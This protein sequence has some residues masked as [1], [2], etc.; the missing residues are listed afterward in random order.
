MG[1]HHEDDPERRR[2]GG[3]RWK[4]D[5]TDSIPVIPAWE[6][7]DGL[8]DSSVDAFVAAIHSTNPPGL[9]VPAEHALY[10]WMIERCSD[11]DVAG[12]PIRRNAWVTVATG[13][14]STPYP[15]TRIA[16]QDILDGWFLWNGVTRPDVRRLHTIWT[17]HATEAAW[18]E[19]LDGR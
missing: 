12:D 6:E 17:R 8:T 7:H 4:G 10:N 2:S 9:D 13:Y 3:L 5:T 19:R 16:A 11:R 18:T 1:R 14:S 15:N